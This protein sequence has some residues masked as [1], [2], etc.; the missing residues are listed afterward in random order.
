MTVNRS[1]LISATIAATGLLAFGAVSTHAQDAPQPA[2]ATAEAL[3]TLTEV[4]QLLKD[5]GLRM[6]EFEV[7]DRVVEA[8]GYDAQNRK[9]EILVD[10]R[11]GEILRQ[12]LDD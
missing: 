2:P 5:K 7:K 4:E 6:T 9:V 8:E 10:R 3:L 1:K 11:S 12:E